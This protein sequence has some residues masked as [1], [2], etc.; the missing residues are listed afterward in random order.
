M[1]LVSS[2]SSAAGEGF[3]AVGV[4]TFVWP[5]ARMDPTMPGQRRGIAKRLKRDQYGAFVSRPYDL[6]CHNARTCAAFRR[7]ERANGLSVQSAG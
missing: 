4:R 2:E 7:Y 1:V 3:L 5:L 6:P